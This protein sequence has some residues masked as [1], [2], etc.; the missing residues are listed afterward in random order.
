MLEHIE[1]DCSNLV[2]G[3]MEVNCSQEE[4]QMAFACRGA[5]F[6]FRIPS[7]IQLYTGQA[8]DHA[9]E[10]TDRENVNLLQL[11]FA[12]PVRFARQW[13]KNTVQ[14]DVVDRII[15]PPATVDGSI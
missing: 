1:S 10:R 14:D 3:R 6:Q 4:V 11:C 2:I 7:T 8:Q 9:S 12:L 5:P 15:G 13:I